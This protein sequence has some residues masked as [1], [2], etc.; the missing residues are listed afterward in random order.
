MG[1]SQGKNLLG[2]LLSVVEPSAWPADSYKDIWLWKKECLGY[3]QFE[4]KPRYPLIGAP[5]GDVLA[6]VK[7]SLSWDGEAGSALLEQI[8]KTIDRGETGWV[9]V[10]EM[11]KLRERLRE[12][13]SAAG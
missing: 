4:K 6:M 9:A 12:P 2:S 11:R 7:G 5:V 10:G 8:A 1:A 13:E 3:Y